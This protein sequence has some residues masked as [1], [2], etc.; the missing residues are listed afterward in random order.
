TL[1]RCP[2][3]R[4]GTCFYQKHA[5]GTFPD[6]VR[7][8]EIEEK[9]GSGTY[10]LVAD[11]EGLLSLVQVG[12]LEIHP[13]GS[14]VDRPDRPDRI[15]FDLDPGEDV[16]FGAV[17]ETALALREIL[18]A[19][20]LEAFARTTGGKGLHV[21]VPIT[22]RSTW[23]EVK[24]FARSVA[25]RLRRTAL[26][27]FVLTASKAQRK[28]RIFLDYLRNDRGATAIA[29][30]ATR[31]RP[32]APVA[33][34]VAWDEVTESLDPKALHVRSVPDRLR[35]IADPWE[36]FFGVRQS[37]GAAVRARLADLG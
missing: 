5:H 21:V 12:V 35:R 13:W 36:G 34:A 17:V 31:A 20:G 15:V 30:Y 18:T 1:L 25:D 29:S 24:E 22:R 32:G 14:R 26:E 3:G 28:G 11:L 16:G 27:R 7:G 10:V 6:A 23:P 19:V 9:E 8:V 33:T 2:R 37:L 4:S